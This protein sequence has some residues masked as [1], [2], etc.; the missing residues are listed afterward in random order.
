[1]K[2]TTGVFAFCGLALAAFAP[3]LA[4]GG[5]QPSLHHRYLMKG[6]I[7]EVTSGEVYLC[8][9][10]SDGAEAGQVLDV[11]RVSRI[12]SGPK[13]GGVGFIRKPVGKVRIDAVVDE[14]FAR[15]TVVSGE[16]LKGDIVEL[17]Q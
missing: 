12:P 1:M 2:W 14:H 17:V 10:R 16:A 4:V 6:S 13:A 8:V 11:V 7:V 3:V 9:G 5:E 15:A